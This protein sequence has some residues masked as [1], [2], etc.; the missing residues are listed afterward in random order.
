[1]LAPHPNPVPWHIVLFASREIPSYFSAVP[2]VLPSSSQPVKV[3]SRTIP[4]FLRPVNPVPF[5]PVIS[6]SRP[7]CPVQSRDGSNP[8]CAV[9][10]SRYPFLPRPGESRDQSIPR[11]PVSRTKDWS[12]GKSPRKFHT[13]VYAIYVYIYIYIYIYKCGSPCPR[14]GACTVRRPL[15]RSQLVCTTALHRC[16]SVLLN[17]GYELCIIKK[18]VIFPPRWGDV[19]AYHVRTVP[20]LI[21]HPLRRLIAARLPARPPAPPP[22]KHEQ[23]PP[24]LL[25]RPHKRALRRCCCVRA[26]GGAG[27]G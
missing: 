19:G 2:F 13:G 16:P 9:P 18:A 15:S 8:P 23:G 25:R 7:T 24:T 10:C 5:N 11:D 14:F 12:R 21:R 27:H 17:D 4:C 22:S 26:G 6:Q 3:P 20:L 1:M